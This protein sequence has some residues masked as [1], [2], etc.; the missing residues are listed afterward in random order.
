MILM[1]LIILIIIA[2]LCSKATDDMNWGLPFSAKH[3]EVFPARLLSARGA[4]KSARVR[5]RALMGQI[6]QSR[7]VASRKRPWCNSAVQASPNAACASQN[8]NT[9]CYMHQRP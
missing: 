9:T 5:V 3:S 7:W 2:T 1:I 4:D 6:V 8:G